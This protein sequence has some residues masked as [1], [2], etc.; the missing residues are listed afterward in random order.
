MIKKIIYSSL[1]DAYNRKFDNKTLIISI[2][3]YS[4]RFLRPSFEGCRDKIE[5][6]FK[7][8]SEEE[9]GYCGRW[10]DKTSEYFNFVVLNEDNERLFDITDA[11]KILNFFD[12]Y[13]KIDEELDL[14][15]HC[16]SGVSRSAAVALF[17][18]RCYN[19]P[20]EGVEPRFNPNPRIIRLMTVVKGS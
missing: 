11:E 4:H 6:S 8:R 3:D 5:L 17:L 2:L 9:L 1:H 16:R 20:F 12:K 10:P 14:F 15:I 18:G 13:H 19:I 7:D